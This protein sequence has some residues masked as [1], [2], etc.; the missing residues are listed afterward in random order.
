MQRF[1]YGASTSSPPKDAQA[2]EHS[3][4]VEKLTL[5]PSPCC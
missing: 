2:R 1:S 3:E 4:T 5:P